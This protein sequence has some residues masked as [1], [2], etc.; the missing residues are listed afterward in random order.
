[1][2][3]PPGETV[4]AGQRPFRVLRWTAA[5]ILVGCLAGAAVVV[6][7]TV[8]LSPVNDHAT[9]LANRTV[10]ADQ[11]LSA[12]IVASE[13]SQSAFHEALGTTDQTVRNDAINR[14]QEGFRDEDSAFGRY[15]K[16][17]GDSRAERELQKTYRN[18]GERSR[19]LGGVLIGTSPTDPTFAAKLASEQAYYDQAQTA[20]NQI[21][22]RFYAAAV[23]GGAQSVVSDGRPHA[24]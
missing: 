11:A 23:A 24:W 17:T 1:M 20:L 22:S 14:A 2:E 13:L 4:A 12:A 21:Q 5:L 16:I 18:A 3:R 10:P 19:A 7:A 6:A 9:T 8:A 15:L